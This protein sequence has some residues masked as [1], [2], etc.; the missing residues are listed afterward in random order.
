[1]LRERLAKVKPAPMGCHAAAMG[2]HARL[3]WPAHGLHPVL[4]E[5][6][7]RL[8]CSWAAGKS[9]QLP[10]LVFHFSDLDSNCCKIQKIVQVGFEV[11]KL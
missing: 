2:H 1:V 4:R 5:Q 6:A 9:A 3:G 11:R 8:V 7:A 10:F